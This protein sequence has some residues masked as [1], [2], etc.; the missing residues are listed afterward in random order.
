MSVD[1]R[2]FAGL[3]PSDRLALYFRALLSNGGGEGARSL[4]GELEAWASGLGPRFAAKEVLPHLDGCAGT[5]LEP[6]QLGDRA[7]GLAALFV[8]IALSDAVRGERAR[9]VSEDALG[10]SGGLEFDSRLRS[11]FVPR[12]RRADHGLPRRNSAYFSPA[13][14]RE[15]VSVDRLARPLEVVVAP[16]ADKGFTLSV[17]VKYRELLN[18]LETAQG[19]RVDDR[20]FVLELQASSVFDAKDFS[21]GDVCEFANLQELSSDRKEGELRVEWSPAGPEALIRFSALLARGETLTLD[22][23]KA[24]PGRGLARVG[25]AMPGQGPARL[26]CLVERTGPVLRDC[27]WADLDPQAPPLPW[28]PALN[29][30]ARANTTGTGNP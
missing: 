3:H 26:D 10:I 15:N 9:V 4:A 5:P 28:H 19:W 27:F 29:P 14:L 21:L 6:M 17:T 16:S 18:W 22:P 8:R 20:R 13:A 2:T 30:P 25:L 1:A 11:R 24:Y 7:R 12:F 23:G